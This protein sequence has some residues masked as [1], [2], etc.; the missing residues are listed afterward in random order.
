MTIKIIYLIV[1]NIGIEMDVTIYDYI[2]DNLYL[3]GLPSQIVKLLAETEDG[4]KIYLYQ[5]GD[6]NQH[7]Q[8]G[9]K[10]RIIIYKDMIYLPKI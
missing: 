3:N 10:I 7:Y 8:I 4:P 1:K 2:N 5:L 6:S 9:S